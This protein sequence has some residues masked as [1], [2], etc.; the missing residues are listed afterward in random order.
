MNDYELESQKWSSANILFFNSFKDILLIKP[1]GHKYWLMPGGGVRVNESPQAAVVRWV[2]EQIGLD[3]EPARVLGVN[4][5][6]RGGIEEIRTTFFGGTL[7]NKQ[8]GTITLGSE[9]EEYQFYDFDDI[10]SPNLLSI[11]MQVEVQT[12][13]CSFYREETKN[14]VT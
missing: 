3:I 13:V 14:R 5:I 1:I 7:T 8:M 4:Y 9:L 2:K 12:A 6:N 11:G 10:A